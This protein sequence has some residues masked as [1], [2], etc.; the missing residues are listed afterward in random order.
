MRREKQRYLKTA[1][2]CIYV[3]NWYFKTQ[4]DKKDGSEILMVGQCVSGSV[5]VWF[6]VS[7][8]IS[9]NSL[10]ENSQLTENMQ[11]N[12]CQAFS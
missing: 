12:L 1:W 9:D 8:K 11:P 5:S 3:F 4:V 2:G 6:T 7:D 10:C